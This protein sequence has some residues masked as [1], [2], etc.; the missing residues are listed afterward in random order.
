M[1]RRYESVKEE[2]SSESYTD[3]WVCLKLYME[4]G[5]LYLE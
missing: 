3:V 1:G 4:S 2:S 5:L